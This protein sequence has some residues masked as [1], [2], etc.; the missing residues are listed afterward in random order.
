MRC[1][2]GVFIDCVRQATVSQLLMMAQ[3]SLNTQ[4]QSQNLPKLKLSNHLPATFAMPLKSKKYLHIHK[5]LGFISSPTK[6]KDITMPNSAKRSISSGSL[7]SLN[8]KGSTRP[9]TRYLKTT[10]SF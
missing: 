1:P 7:N 8:P 4:K 10:P 5:W 3:S 6:N 9:L 2:L